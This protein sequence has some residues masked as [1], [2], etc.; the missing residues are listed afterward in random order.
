M[1]VQAT[2]IG[3]AVYSLVVSDADLRENGDVR[4]RTLS[5]VSCQHMYI[6]QFI[7]ILGS[8]HWHYINFNCNRLMAHSL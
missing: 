3:T 7:N 2:A 6:H 8:I 4:F 5:P 1:L